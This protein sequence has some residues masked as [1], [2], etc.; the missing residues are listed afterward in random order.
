MIKL[1]ALDIDGTLLNSSGKISKI[2]KQAIFE[3]K[4]KGVKIVICTGRTFQGVKDIL[5]ELEL[6]EEGCYL[7]AFNGALIHTLPKAEIF[8]RKSLTYADFEEIEKLSNQLQIPYHIQSDDGT[9][10]T[11]QPVGK[12]TLLDC[13]L[14]NSALFYREKEQM[15]TIP[16]NKIM[17]VD[18]SR[19][20]E[21]KIAAIP[22]YFYRKYSLVRSHE[23]FFE[24]LNKAAGKG[25]ALSVLSANLKISPAEIVAIGDNDNDL[26][27][28]QYAGV[29]I[30]M[31]N[32]SKKL[33]AAADN[34]TKSNDEDGVAHALMSF[35]TDRSD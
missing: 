9:Y 17:F 34:I 22:A 4:K 5:K 7:I 18:E 33:I 19:R 23:S 11:N 31:G 12:Y 20:L 3:Q 6:L 16:I 29:G 24:F 8:Y 32:A 10:T 13:Q 1:I 14:N 35:L 26:S 28:I 15:A 2:T 30:A 25:E 27:M 21:E